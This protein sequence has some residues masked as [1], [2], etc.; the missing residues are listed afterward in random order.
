MRAIGGTYFAT[1]QLQWDLFLRFV[2]KQAFILIL[3]AAINIL[4]ISP[5]IDT[6]SENSGAAQDVLERLLG[7]FA[8]AKSVYNNLTTTN[9]DL[10]NTI[11]DLHTLISTNNVMDPNAY[12]GLTWFNNMTSFITILSI[13]EAT[14]VQDMLDYIKTDI[15]STQRASINTIVVVV[16]IFVLCPPI[17]IWYTISN[18]QLMGKLQKY[19]LEV[20]NRYNNQQDKKL[21]VKLIGY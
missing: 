1:G 3:S 4:E 14:V 5:V 10:I 11:S 2:G 21:A 7:R 19:I 15:A 18:I 17:I 16:V 6:D 9:S 12:M 20:C 13:V 8:P